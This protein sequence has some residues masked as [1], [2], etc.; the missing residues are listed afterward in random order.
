MTGGAERFHPDLS[1]SK[2]EV[3]AHQVVEPFSTP[4][5]IACR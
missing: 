2:T 4:S 5:R 1:A 3:A